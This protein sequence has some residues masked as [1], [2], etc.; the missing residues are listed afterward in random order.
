MKKPATRPPKAEE[1]C[2][3]GR[4]PGYVP[5]KIVTYTSEELLEAIGP[6]LACSPSPCGTPGSPGRS[7]S[8][9]PK[10]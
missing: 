7:G 3:E 1:H 2:G 5:P 9:Y 4:L 6:A 10:R 8:S